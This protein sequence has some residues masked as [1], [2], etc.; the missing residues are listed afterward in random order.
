MTLKYS[1]LTTVFNTDPQ[2]FMA[3]A[4]NILRTP[5]TDFEWV[6]LDNGSSAE[7]TL[8]AIAA[9]VVDPRVK[10]SRVPENLGIVGGMRH[11][12]DKS[13]GQYILPVDSDDL[14]ASDFLEVID[15]HT[16]R[17]PDTLAFYSD[18][19]RLMNDKVYDT[20]KKP[21][22]DPIFF[23]H[24]CYIA[25]QCVFNRDLAEKVGIYTDPET[26]GSHDWDTYVRFLMAG[27][28]IRRINKTLYFWRMHSGSTALNIESKNYIMSSHQAVLGKWIEYRNLGAKVGLR[29]SRHLN[30]LGNWE[31]F[32]KSSA[33]YCDVNLEDCFTREIAGD[34]AWICLHASG[35]NKAANDV[36]DT[37]ATMQLYD[38]IA[39]AGGALSN[40][41]HR[42]D[43]PR[44]AHMHWMHLQSDTT[45]LGY[46]ARNTKPH[47]CQLLSSQFIV[48][49]RDHFLSA[50]NWLASQGF[51]T[52]K[53]NMSDFS[54]LA[55][56]WARCN[57]L[58]AMYHPNLNIVDQTAE[59]LQPM[60]AATA[61]L[62]YALLGQAEMQ[63][64]SGI[65]GNDWALGQRMS[66][67]L[68]NLT[69]TN[70]LSAADFI[71]FQILARS[72]R[73]TNLGSHLSPSPL[74]IITSVYINTSLQYFEALASSILSQSLLPHEWIIVRNGPVQKDVEAA[75]QRLAESHIVRVLDIAENRGIGPALK[76]A[77]NEVTAA[78]FVV[79]DADDLLVSDAIRTLSDYVQ[80][81][82]APDLVYSDECIMIDETP[83]YLCLREAFDRVLHAD[84]S[85]IWHMV[86]VRKDA[87]DITRFLANPDTQWATDWEFV[88]NVAS[89]EDA[90]ILHCPEV[91]YLWRQHPAS[92][93]NNTTGDNR[94]VQ[95]QRAVLN[96]YICQ[97]GLQVEVWPLDRGAEELYCTGDV[98]NI[99]TVLHFSTARFLK[100][101]N[102]DIAELVKQDQLVILSQMN[103]LWA[104]EVFY[105]EALRLLKLHNNIDAVTGNLLSQDGTIIDSPQ[106]HVGTRRYAPWSGKTNGDSGTFAVLQ[107]VQGVSTVVSGNCAFKSRQAAK[108]K[109]AIQDHRY[110]LNVAWSPL[111]DRQIATPKTGTKKRIS[112]LVS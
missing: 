49:P 14:L 22:F 56:Y 17:Y 103:T 108:V 12:F 8:D 81:H 102:S 111:L 29:Q 55:S 65:E 106:L 39:I 32:A 36:Q 87:L 94:S 16:A 37:I 4:E 54:L 90:R 1:I 77:V 97:D 99:E 73:A 48:M 6:L 26:N 74:S 38:G 93:S 23:L 96:D 18:E 84:S 53:I 28:D 21:E 30:M 82:D 92:I 45:D 46:F 71:R 42:V 95:S 70:T 69:A 112:V 91:T 57:G 41:S 7:N 107:K 85:T 3:I 98:K 64:I 88:A 66:H 2:Y 19:S 109:Q 89:R 44:Y 75:L 59:K 31:F 78:Y 58:Y 25:H 63:P 80:A 43:G 34:A 11:V 20:Y 5:R 10:F 50:R 15:E 35:V 101:S 13:I 40:A 68:M 62:G 83:T 110:C 67:L 72:V 51:G 76:M 104:T 60:S 27:A 100:L 47:L 61:A 86:I 24:S 33:T 52:G 9:V 105:R 79:C